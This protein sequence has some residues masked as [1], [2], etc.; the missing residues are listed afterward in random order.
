MAI[1]EK[2]LR[3]SMV[4]YCEQLWDRRLVSGT[5]GNVSVR[6]E[7]G[8]VLATPAGRSLGRLLPGDIVRVDALG[9]PRDAAQRPTSELPLHLAA[10]RA[11]PDAACLIHTHPTFCVVWSKCGTIF[12][13]DTV[14]ARETL[15]PVAWTAF[16]PAGSAELAALCA[17][18]FARGFD[19]VLME[20][21]GLSTLGKTLEEAFVLTDLAEEAARIAY[22]SRLANVGSDDLTGF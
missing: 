9:A 13:Q 10:Y 17:G 18:E 21:H 15:G 20:R 16:L 2:D 14:G 4:R 3:A 12:P 5:S 19:T 7:D 6:L 22:F 1:H 11:R 8:D